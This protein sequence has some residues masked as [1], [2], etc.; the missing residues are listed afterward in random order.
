L[1]YI[2]IVPCHVCLTSDVV[3]LS[4]VGG[5]VPSKGPSIYDVHM[6][7]GFLTPLPSVH[8]RPHKPDPPAPLV[9]VHMPSEKMTPF[10]GNFSDFGYLANFLYFICQNC[11]WLFLILCVD[12]HMRLTPL[13]RPHW[14][15]P[16]SPP[17]GRHKWMA[18]KLW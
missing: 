14:P 11:W 17:R 4:G 7:I 5:I 12:V 15:D 6:R 9:D 3:W 2:V 13:F 16:L 8:M 10:L 18:P 1:L